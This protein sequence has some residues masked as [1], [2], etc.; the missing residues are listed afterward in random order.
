[1]KKTVSLSR[2]CKT[3]ML[4]GLAIIYLGGN[5]LVRYRLSVWSVFLPLLVGFFPMCFMQ[6]PFTPKQ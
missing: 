5:V 3:A 1:M 6:A 4:A 2:E